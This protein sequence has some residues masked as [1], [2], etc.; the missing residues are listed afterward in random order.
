MSESHFKS[1]IPNDNY[2]DN[3]DRI[4]NKRPSNEIVPAKEALEAL[5]KVTE[6]DFAPV[7][8]DCMGDPE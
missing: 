7:P 3:F 5:K 6:V 2:K 8:R 1:M 4:F